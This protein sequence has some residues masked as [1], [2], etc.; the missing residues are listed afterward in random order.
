MEPRVLIVEDDLASMQL[1]WLTLEGAGYRLDAATTRRDALHLVRSTDYQA[2]VLDIGLPELDG[3]R[4]AREIRSH[5]VTAALPL[6]AVSA[7]ALGEEIKRACEAG[8]DLYLTK[9]VGLVALRR[10]VERV[11]RE[12]A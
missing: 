5:P 1:L 7:H 8:I 12:H 9:P 4:L 11:I 6:V 10:A 2:A 3:A